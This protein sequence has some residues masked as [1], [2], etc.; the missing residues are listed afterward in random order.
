MK[1]FCITIFSLLL[2]GASVAEAMPSREH[3]TNNAEY[4][5]TG[6]DTIYGRHRRYYYGEWFDTCRYY[7]NESLPCP[8]WGLGPIAMRWTSPNY[9]DQLVAK[10][11][12]TD[13]PLTIKG[14]TALV[15]DQ[16]QWEEYDHTPVRGVGR[17]PEALYL[18]QKGASP[19]TTCWWDNV[20]SNVL[21]FIDSVRWDTS[22]KQHL[23][24]FPKT[25]HSEDYIY[26]HAYDVYFD[27]PVTV[28]SVFYIAGTFRSSGRVP[29]EVYQYS[30]YYPYLPTYYATYQVN[31]G[32]FCEPSGSCF[33]SA[34]P[35]GGARYWC[36][37]SN[38][39]VYGY[40]LPIIDNDS[41][42]VVP[43]DTTH[44]YT[45]GSG[46][47]PSGHTVEFIAVA[48]SGYVFSH[49]NDGDTVNPRRVTMS[50]D[51][52]FVAYFSAT[53]SDTTE[54]LREAG[55]GPRLTVSPNP[56]HTLLDV[57]CEEQ[58]SE[59]AL[60]DAKGRTMIRQYP[61][62]HKATLDVS[63]LPTG[64]YLVTVWTPRGKATS[65][66]VVE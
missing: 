47:I 6:G 19:S 22:H 7:M 42:S 64:V 34:P 59:I 37:R 38:V 57:S 26:M 52:T 54:S 18:Y 29:D 25:A 50:Q 48:R 24:F 53:G 21:I 8:N 45:L 3:S 33:E 36:Q 58:M 62:T 20:D 44:G 46:Y 23:M 39:N 40:Y 51:T 41:L 61:K 55:G 28:D 16:H 17:R 14:L 65:K 56:V 12:Y 35:Q 9:Q 63:Q 30:F 31:Q 11:M 5:T 13:E 49:W 60:T 32:P 4:T 2:A 43:D 10:E 66:V 27:K 15:V 1:S